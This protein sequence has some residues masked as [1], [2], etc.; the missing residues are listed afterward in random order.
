MK[1]QRAIHTHTVD[2][3]SIEVHLK[4]QYASRQTIYK[5]LQYA[6]GLAPCHLLR[7]QYL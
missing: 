3:K 7:V 1:F 4:I 5:K 6:L 2:E